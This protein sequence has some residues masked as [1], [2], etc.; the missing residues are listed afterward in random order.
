M[1]ALHQEIWA[2]HL[3]GGLNRWR[4][5]TS[6]GSQSLDNFRYVLSSRIHGTNVLSDSISVEKLQRSMYNGPVIRPDPT[7]INKGRRRKIR[8]PMVMDEMK[9]R[10]N[11]LP[12]RSQA[13]SKRA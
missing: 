7:K 1:A 9:D 12:T 10:I 5:M 8:I 11:R 2:Q 4:I 3:D 6:N 13:R